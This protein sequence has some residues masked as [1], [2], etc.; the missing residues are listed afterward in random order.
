MIIR[1][2][3]NIYIQIDVNTTQQS[4]VRIKYVLN[5]ICRLLDKLLEQPTQ[6]EFT[7]F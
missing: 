4:Q 6:Q 7:S 5:Y 1:W 3:R 2:N